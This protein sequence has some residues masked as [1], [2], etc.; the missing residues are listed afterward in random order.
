MKKNL[1]AAVLIIM[2]LGTLVLAGC[3]SV[4]ASVDQEPTSVYY[5]AIQEYSESEEDS[6]VL[7]RKL[8][9]M[10]DEMSEGLLKIKIFPSGKLVD[11]FELHKGVRDGIIDAAFSN[12]ALWPVTSKKAAALYNIK[13]FA[14]EGKEFIISEESWD[15]LPDNLK[16]VLKSALKEC[17][18]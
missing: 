7:S 1:L 6:Y 5:L 14:S 9:D 15:K 3:S 12:P 13:V 4:N 18:F 2:L 11:A 8:A 16:E 17:G 10:I